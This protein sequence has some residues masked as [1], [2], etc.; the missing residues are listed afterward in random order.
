MK[1]QTTLKI[2]NRYVNNLT[3]CISDAKK[4]GLLGAV[5]QFEVDRAAM[6]EAI[7]CMERS[8]T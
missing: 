3:L 6:Q 8:N 5:Q 2:L 4:D 1:K 7:K